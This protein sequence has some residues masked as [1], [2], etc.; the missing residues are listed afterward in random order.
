[1]PVN[2]SNRSMIVS[3]YSESSSMPKPRRPV[4]GDIANKPADFADNVDNEGMTAVKFKTV[5]SETPAVLT[6]L[7]EAEDTADCPSGF[8]AVGG[9]YNLSGTATGM[10]DATVW[11]S[12]PLDSNTW[13]VAGVRE[14]AVGEV[15]LYAWVTCPRAEPAGLVIAA[16]NSDHGPKKAHVRKG[17]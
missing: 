12:L 14:G 6:Q 10:A 7:I 2:R 17:K 13:P 5:V 8:F 3:Q 4:W 9:G 15:G 16:K 1:M 11:A